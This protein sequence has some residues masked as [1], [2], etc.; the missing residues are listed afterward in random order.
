MPPTRRNPKRG[1][2]ER[3]STRRERNVEIQKHRQSQAVHTQQCN[4]MKKKS[5]GGRKIIPLNMGSVVVEEA[6]REQRSL[7]IQR[8]RDEQYRTMRKSE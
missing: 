1:R 8:K 4:A 2:R 3:R 6:Q 5:H 7:E